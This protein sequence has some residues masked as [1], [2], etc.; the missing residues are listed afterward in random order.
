MRFGATMSLKLKSITSR[1]VYP[2]GP[3]WEETESAA[4]FSGGMAS[5]VSVLRE[6]T[7]IL[8][9][10]GIAAILRHLLSPCLKDTHPYTIF[11]LPAYLLS[12]LSG[13]KSG[14][15]VLVLGIITGQVL[16]VGSGSSIGLECSEVVIGLILSLGV[17]AA[18]IYFAATSRRDRSRADAANERLAAIVESSDDAIIGKSLKG[19]VRT[20]NQGAERL[21]GYTADEAIGRP[22]SLIIPPELMEEERTIL[23]QIRRGERVNHY[24]TQRITKDGR[25]VE[26]SLSVSPLR[27]RKKRVAGASK[28]ARDITARKATEEAL[29]RSRERF[30]KIVD[31]APGVICSIRLR[32]D[33]DLSFPYS[34]PGIFKIIGLRSEEL[35]RDAAAILEMIHP[36]DRTSFHESMQRS[37]RDKTPWRETFRVCPAAG[38]ESWV[39]I[40]SVP[41]G[42]PEGSVIWHGFMTDV[43]A[44]K[45]DE[46]VLRLQNAMLRAQTE[47]APDGILTVDNGGKILSYNRHM[48]EIWEISE[49]LLQ[50][51]DS[52]LFHGL[53]ESKALDPAEFRSKLAAIRAEPA[54]QS[55]DEVLLADG[56]ILD[57]F[58]A[59]IREEGGEILGRVWYFRD[60]TER[61]KLEKEILKSLNSEKEISEMKSRFIAVASHEFRTPLTAL[62]GSAELLLDRGEELTPS[63]RSEL[64]RRILA[65]SHRLTAIMDDVLELS[66]VDAGKIKPVKSTTDLPL[67]FQDIIDEIKMGDKMKHAVQLRTVGDC[68]TVHTDPKM[69]RHIV[70]NLLSNAAHYSPE[71]SPIKMDLHCEE[72]QYWFEVSDQGVGIPEG[73]RKDLF[74][75]FFR[76]SNVGMVSGS[77]LGLS[78]I[79]KY[80]EL[81]GG[82]VM[83]MPSQIGTCFRVTIPLG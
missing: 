27:D 39:E 3:N 77:G 67:R 8:L 72:K 50:G 49:P 13:W 18:G 32:A 62:A 41:C 54:L 17:G 83:L 21:F 51:G 7:K 64:L 78:I 43:T 36:E 71:G 6:L 63:K 33:G 25:R 48:L 9:V 10:V 20:W 42:E 40:N 46:S 60:I 24:E 59:P 31:T 28:I 19:V 56:R 80:A 65:G 12:R 2:Q 14:A 53:A 75:P 73:D 23:S 70:S 68:G 57:R 15:A 44:R 35:S 69:I 61:R 16:F 47:A 45:K 34:S 81:L 55:R 30:D 26:I 82:Q 29:H 66:K 11:L 4:P 52:R 1:G 37:A 74:E 58:S 22:I 76:A 79:K 5:V 38:T